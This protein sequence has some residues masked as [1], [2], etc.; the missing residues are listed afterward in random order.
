MNALIVSLVTIALRIG[1]W[2]VQRLSARGATWMQHYME[3]KVED[4]GRRLARAKMKWRIQFLKGRI[5]RW[6]R[7]IAWLKA[8][9]KRVTK[10]VADGA[11]KRLIAK[12]IPIVAPEERAVAA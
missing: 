9:A 11:E 8:N 3:G 12:K 5:A 6:N 1:R 2:L 10:Q 4:F 7:A